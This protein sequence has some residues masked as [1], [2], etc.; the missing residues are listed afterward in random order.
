[1]FAERMEIS[2]DVGECGEGSGVHSLIQKG[3]NIK[4]LN[5]RDQ[6]KNNKLRHG[7]INMKEIKTSNKNNRSKQI[8]RPVLDENL[9]L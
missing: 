1:M 3:L 2:S 5:Y 8:Y 6:K 4:I 7:N 9:S